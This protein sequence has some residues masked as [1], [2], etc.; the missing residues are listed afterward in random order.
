M[1]RF[2]L[3]QGAHSC[4]KTC[5]GMP[6]PAQQGLTLV[7]LLVGMAVGFIVLASAG[8]VLLL[9]LRTTG[10]LELAQR[11]RDNA[12]RLDYLIQIE[13]SEAALVETGR[14]LSA[15][16]GASGV[17]SFATFVVPRDEGDYQSSQNVSFIHYYNQDGNVW[18]CG[19]PVAAN[20]VL[21]HYDSDGNPSGLQSGI[22]VREASLVVPASGV[23]QGQVT[24]ARQLVYRLAFDDSAY[25]PECSIARVRTV[26]ID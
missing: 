26:R 15:C 6:L 7:E 9:H 8:V 17:S 13:A 11:Q 23:C 4:F 19:P 22:A 3:A 2:K 18:R 14:S 5:G 24:N 21:V 12:V 10:G 16:E 20:G 1:D 25:V